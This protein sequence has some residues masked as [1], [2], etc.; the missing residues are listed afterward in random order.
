MHALRDLS[1]YLFSDLS[2]TMCTCGEL[3]LQAHHKLWFTMNLLTR[4]MQSSA[5][6]TSR[7]TCAW[8]CVVIV[9]LGMTLELEF[10]LILG[11]Q[12]SA[13]Q[14]SYNGGA[15]WHLLDKPSNFTHAQCDLCSQ[16]AGKSASETT[17]VNSTCMAPLVGLPVK[18][19]PSY[20]LVIVL[21]PDVDLCQMI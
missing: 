12:S 9:A 15:H 19:R 8:D 20:P 14:V 1:L 4:I 17:P 6:H 10:G 2:L 13:P 11:K 3:V 18:A 7:P 21:V 5:E 16:Q